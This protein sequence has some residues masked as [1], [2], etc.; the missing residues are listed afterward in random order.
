M[1]SMSKSPG[2]A[3]AA[4]LLGD[5]VQICLVTRDH[6]RTMD[7]LLA[8]GIGPWRIHTHHPGTTRETLLRGEAHAFTCIMAYAH[9]A[10]VMWEIVE[11]VAGSGI[12][13]EFLEQRG[14][15]VHHVGFLCRDRSFAAAIVEFDRRGYQV[16]QSG[17]VWNGRVGYAF[18]GTYDALGLYFEIWDHPPGFGPPDPECWYPAP[19]P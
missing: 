18:I 8:L 14:E 6:I 2:L 12:F 5:M 1:V 7:H 16:V 9:S 4:D 19:P 15:G 10:N 17:R 3:M 11:P 13:S